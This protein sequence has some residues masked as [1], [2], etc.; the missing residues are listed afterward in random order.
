MFFCGR[1]RRDARC[2]AFRDRLVADAHARGEFFP[3]VVRP[4]G[5]HHK[6]SAKREEFGI[7]LDICDESEHLRGRKRD[8]PLS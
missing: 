8:V 6:A 4:P 7:A 5:H 2:E 3:T 1:V